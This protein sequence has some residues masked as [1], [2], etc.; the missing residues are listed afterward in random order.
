ML[1]SP[2]VVVAAMTPDGWEQRMPGLQVKVLWEKAP[3]GAAITLVKFDKGAGIPEPHVHASNQFMYCL[4]GRYEY[5]PNNMVLEPGAFYWNP[6]D[7]EHG[8]TVAHEESIL[9]EIYD[10][11]RFYERPSYLQ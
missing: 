11:Q 7:H 9:L 2:E 8:P 6:K 1:V 5:L 4:S 3:G 10:G